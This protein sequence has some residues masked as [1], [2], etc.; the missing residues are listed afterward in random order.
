MFAISLTRRMSVK[1]MSG[2]QEDNNKQNVETSH[3]FN[4]TSRDFNGTSQDEDQLE[5]S[6]I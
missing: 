5:F 6:D 4:G 1:K 2:S 3:D